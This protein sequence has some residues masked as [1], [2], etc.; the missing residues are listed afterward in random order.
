MSWVYGCYPDKEAHAA[1]RSATPSKRQKRQ[2]TVSMHAEAN[3][4]LTF[5]ARTWR[6]N[7]ETQ[8]HSKRFGYNRKEAK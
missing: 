2:P 7:R 1:F 4:F 3:D 5:P 8:L 6:G